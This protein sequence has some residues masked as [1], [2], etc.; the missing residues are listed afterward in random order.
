[1]D[2]QVYFGVND[3]PTAQYVSERLGEATITTWSENGGSTRTRN[4]DTLG[5]E[6]VSTS[7]NTGY[8][9]QETGRRLL[10]PEE[11]LGL[12]ERLAV[13]FAPQAPPFVT[14]LV[15]HYEPEFRSRP[16]RSR[17]SNLWLAGKCTLL[18]AA[19]VGLVSALVVV[20]VSRWETNRTTAP[21][22]P[23]QKY[24]PAAKM[25]APVRPAPAEQPH[26]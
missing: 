12:D 18:A 2:V 13:V 3:L 17:L 23:V 16:K 7:S 26:G 11:V 1:M 21:P 25:V 14:R 20:G 6:S 10:K 15:R 22:P 24:V 19:S 8:G 5:M 4:Y 9:A